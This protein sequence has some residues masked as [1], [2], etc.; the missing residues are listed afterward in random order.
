[1]ALIN[2]FL[3]CSYDDFIAD[4]LR[5]LFACYRWLDLDYPPL[6]T[7][8]PSQSD[9]SNPID[10]STLASGPGVISIKPNPITLTWPG[11]GAHTL[12]T[13]GGLLVSL[14]VL[15]TLLATML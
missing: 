2:V 15:L 5:P 3:V 10:S 8:T 1:M 9:P 6:P 12:H 14:S 13:T 7:N 11:S 4:T